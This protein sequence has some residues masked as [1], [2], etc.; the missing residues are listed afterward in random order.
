MYNR[1]AKRGYD[2]DDGKEFFSLRDLSKQSSICNVVL[3]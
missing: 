1:D 2:D 3:L